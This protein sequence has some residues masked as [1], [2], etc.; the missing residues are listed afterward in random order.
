LEEVTGA[1]VGIF[2]LRSFSVGV[3][4]G[5]FGIER[6]GEKIGKDK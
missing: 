5:N 4:F 6:K 3:V 2:D 1:F